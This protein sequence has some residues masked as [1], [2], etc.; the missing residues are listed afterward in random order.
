MVSTRGVDWVL[1]GV[2]ERR[3]D[4]NIITLVTSC[5]RQERRPRNGEK[6]TR[7]RLT[8]N[9]LHQLAT[10]HFSRET[11]VALEKW[12]NVLLLPEVR[13]G[14]HTFELSVHRHLE[15][16][17]RNHTTPQKRGHT[18]ESDARTGKE[19][20]MRLMFALPPVSGTESRRVLRRKAQW[21]RTGC[22]CACLWMAEE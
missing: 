22:V 1:L 14:C 4:Q 2:F 19:G 5:E 20:A 11:L 3:F 6:R 10:V 21:T 8:W 15:Q 12:D 9:R 13:R 16:D 18:V 17:G 7:M